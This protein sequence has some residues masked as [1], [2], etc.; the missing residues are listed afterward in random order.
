MYNIMQWATQ[1]FSAQAVSHQITVK[2]NPL[3]SNII[4]DPDLITEL[5]PV[6]YN[7][8]FSRLFLGDTRR[9]GGKTVAGLSSYAPEVIIDHYAARMQARRIDKE[10]VEARTLLKRNNAYVIGKGPRLD[11]TPDYITLGISSESAKEWA[12]KVKNGFHLWA[13]SKKS[14]ITGDNNFYQN[15]RFAKHQANRDGGSFPRFFYSDDP[16]LLNPLQIGFIDSNQIRG[17]EFTFT[18]GPLR[19]DTGIK[20]DENG[21]AISYKVW[22]PLQNKPNRYEFV[23]IPVKDEAT[24]RQIMLHIFD[25]EY[26]GQKRGIPKIN[27][28]I[29]DFE[30]I[31]SYNNAQLTRMIN[32][33]SLNFTS[34]NALQDPGDFGFSKL[35]TNAAGII[36]QEESPTPVRPATLS[37]DVVNYQRLD[38]ATLSEPGVNVFEARQGDKLKAT[39]DLSPGETAKDFMESRFDI[40]AP[41]MGMSPE[42]AKMRTNSSFTA[43]K[44]AFGMQ[45]DQADIERD[46]IES[47]FMN[48]AYEMWLSGEI[49]AGRIQ[50]PGWSD[51]ILKEAWLQNRWI[52]APPIDLNPLQTAKANKENASIGAVDLARVAENLNGSDFDSN[53]QKLKDQVQELPHDPF[54]KTTG[55]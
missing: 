16:D 38:E 8:T 44:G 10:S 42:V 31:T 2:H 14:D 53:A 28:A 20:T 30:D 13:K 40:L 21:K 29:Q 47:D 32:G 22:I 35:R 17:D 15:V 4:F 34:E 41:S 48:I 5:T 52:Y 12:K 49:A 46:D 39:P 54:E 50:A 11:P 43:A 18:S 45:D 23:E 25:K 36:I 55:V 7:E 1:K 6:A 3:S 24:G 19:Q 51:P 33:A 37:S 26:A 27:H 9:A